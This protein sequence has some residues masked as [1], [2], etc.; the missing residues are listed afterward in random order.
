MLHQFVKWRSISIGNKQRHIPM[1]TKVGMVVFLFALYSIISFARL[2]WF[3]GKWSTFTS[4]YHG[5]SFDYPASWYRDGEYLTRGPKNLV[6]LNIAFRNSDGLIIP[7]TTG[8]EVHHRTIPDGTLEDVANWGMELISITGGANNISPLID[9]NIGDDNYPVLTQIYDRSWVSRVKHV[10]V[11]S[12]DDAYIV[13][14][15]S[16]SWNWDKAME[17][18]DRVLA[19]FQLPNI[20]SLPTE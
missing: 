1:P 2:L 12:G 20:R 14:L 6:E 16:S 5:F 19:S 8:I 3:H 4:E 10:Y 13:L 18:F 17:I 15:S 9:D 7:P 11:I